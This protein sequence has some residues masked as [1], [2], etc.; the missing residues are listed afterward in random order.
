MPDTIYL[1]DIT[2]TDNQASL[3]VNE[4]NYSV[5]QN[6]DTKYTVTVSDD[7]LNKTIYTINIVPGNIKDYEITE[8]NMTVTADSGSRDI[9]G[10]IAW[11]NSTWD[12]NI[13]LLMDGLRDSTLQKKA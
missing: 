8:K 2:V 4:G 5:A 7:E 11:N 13:K 9:D 3:S 1:S 12:N 10:N 6:D